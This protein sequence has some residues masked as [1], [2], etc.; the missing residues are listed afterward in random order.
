[1]NQKGFVAKYWP[2]LFV[3]VPIGLQLIFF[4]YP[5]FTGI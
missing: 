2:Y 1:M 3:A 5:L 4:F